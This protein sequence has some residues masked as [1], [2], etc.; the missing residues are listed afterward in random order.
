MVAG[1][2]AAEIPSGMVP[3]VTKPATAAPC[4]NPPSTILVFGQLAA[5]DSMTARAASMPA[6]VL[7]AKSLLAG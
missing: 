2:S 5:V 7:T 3:A 1:T 6:G 4:E